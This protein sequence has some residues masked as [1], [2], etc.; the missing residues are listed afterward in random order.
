ME[1]V[2]LAR[3]GTRAVVIPEAGRPSA[4][5]LDPRRPWLA[6]AAAKPGVA[7][8]VAGRPDRLGIVR[9]GAVAG[10][11]RRR[12]VPVARPHTRGAGEQRWTLA[13]RAGSTSR[14]RWTRERRRHAACRS[15]STPAGHSPG[16]R[17]RR[18]PCSTTAC[19]NASKC[20]PRGGAASRRAQ[21]GT[22]GSGVT[23]GG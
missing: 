21:G 20:T 17:Y 12:A 15:S 9:D 6:A 11:H 13:A 4:P 14:G 2:E 1:I 22:R 10:A 8:R 16:V 23:C 19:R 5:A 7:T 3:A 18:S